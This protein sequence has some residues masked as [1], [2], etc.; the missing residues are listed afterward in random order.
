MSEFAFPDALRIRAYPP[1]KCEGAQ[2]YLVESD[3][4]YHSKAFGPVVAPSGMDTDFASVPRLVW[5]YLSPED[6]CILYGSIIHDHLYQRGGRSRDRVFSRAE[7]DELLREAMIVC[8]A[9][10]S[11]AAVVYRVL[12]LFGGKNWKQL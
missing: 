2:L 6:P 1:D 8:G 5:S 10:H 12:R 3:F 9:R 7:A 11:Q 4:V